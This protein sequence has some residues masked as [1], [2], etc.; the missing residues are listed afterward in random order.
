MSSYFDKA[1][2]E[3]REKAELFSG[4]DFLDEILKIEQRVVYEVMLAI[5]DPEFPTDLRTVI[6]G[7]ISQYGIL[8]RV[9]RDSGFSS[10]GQIMAMA[11]SHSYLIER[12]HDA[13]HDVAE[14]KIQTRFGRLYDN[15]NQ[16]IMSRAEYLL[17][18]D[19]K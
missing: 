13:F 15:P 12:L 2:S 10:E 14:R 9:L 17:T 1:S 5:G 19:L 6:T 18:K 16:I 3:V 11:L 7:T 4:E 8:P